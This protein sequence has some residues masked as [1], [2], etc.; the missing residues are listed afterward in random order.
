[1][2][3]KSEAAILDRYNYFKIYCHYDEI[4]VSY[5][6]VRKSPDFIGM[7]EDG[8][9]I[10]HEHFGLM[11]QAEYRNAYKSKLA[12]YE[13]NGIVPWDNLIITFDNPNGSIDVSM[14]DAQLKHFYKI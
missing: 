2:R 8:K 3:S 10:F 7:R 11:N 1:M 4:V 12:F 9:V 14:I 6:G 13:L 5:N